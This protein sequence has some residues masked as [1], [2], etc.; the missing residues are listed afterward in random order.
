MCAIS[1]L[2]DCFGTGMNN[3][4]FTTDDQDN[5][6]WPGN[7]ADKYKSG[8]WHKACHYAYPNGVYLAGNNSIFAVG[9]VYIPWMGHY[10]SLK[11]T[12]LMVRK[13]SN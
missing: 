10:Y 1:L 9:I 3:I 11:S 4:M 5:D 8:W 13:I 12:Q 7:C 6:K 2:D